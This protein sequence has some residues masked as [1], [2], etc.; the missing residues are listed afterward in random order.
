MVDSVVVS[1]VVVEVV[2]FLMLI[3]AFVGLEFSVGKLVDVS[4]VVDV[5]VDGVDVVVM[6]NS[7]LGWALTASV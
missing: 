1:S 4:F 5:V 2:L 7:Q 6:A 3:D